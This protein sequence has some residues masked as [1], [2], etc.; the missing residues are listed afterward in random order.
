[1]KGQRYIFTTYGYLEK[2][3]FGRLR[4]ICD[5]IFIVGTKD[6]QLPIKLVKKAHSW[7]GDLKWYVVDL[8][9][10]GDINNRLSYLLGKQDQKAGDDV[11]FILLSDDS[12]LNPIISSLKAAGRSILRIGSAATEDKKEEEPILLFD[13][14]VEEKEEVT[15]FEPIPIAAFRPGLDE[16]EVVQHSARKTLQKLQNEGHRP[17]NLETLKHYIHLFSSNTEGQRA[18]IDQILE[19]M[20]AHREIKI[21]QGVVK[22]NF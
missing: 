11:E 4:K 10:N 3:R 15:E 6:D 12:G 2:I 7:K 18:S 9:K 21:E 22:Y 13:P 19:Y 17:E 20:E 14:I 5:K 16:N 8:K 1:M